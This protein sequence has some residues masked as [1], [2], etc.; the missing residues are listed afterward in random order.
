[1]PPAGTKGQLSYLEQR[2]L[3]KGVSVFFSYFCHVIQ[4]LVDCSIFKQYFISPKKNVHHTRESSRIRLCVS[5]IQTEELEAQELPQRGTESWFMSLGSP[6]TV[7]RVPR[8]MSEIPEAGSS[9]RG[10]EGWSPFRDNKYH[11]PMRTIPQVFHS[12]NKTQLRHA[13]CALGCCKDFWL[14]LKIH[15]IYIWAK[16]CILF[17]N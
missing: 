6:D 1:M 10:S 15:K 11:S 14:T 13:D 3:E 17:L 12:R 7:P 5:V 8:N 4:L 16:E 9:L 2:V